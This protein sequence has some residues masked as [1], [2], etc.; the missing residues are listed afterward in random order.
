MSQL[1]RPLDV[2][3]LRCC[4]STSKLSV[5]LRLQPSAYPDLPRCKSPARH[6]GPEVLSSKPTAAR[7]RIDTSIK[8]RRQCLLFHPGTLLHT[9]DVQQG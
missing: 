2:L 6:S 3:F 4:Y 7:D 8:S 5:L 1:E 9:A